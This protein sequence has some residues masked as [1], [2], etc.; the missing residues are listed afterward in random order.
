MLKSMLNI[1]A[2]SAVSA[3]TCQEA[4]AAD[5]SNVF[6]A[7]DLG[8]IG[9]GSPSTAEFLSRCYSHFNKSCAFYFY[10]Q[11]T[12]TWHI[13]DMPTGMMMDESIMRIILIPNNRSVI[14][15]Q[16]IS[17]RSGAGSGLSLYSYSS[18]TSTWYMS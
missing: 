4:S 7:S 10:Y 2:N 18:M 17:P 9:T 5:V 14:L 11:P 3:L 6:S 12:S 15:L 16:Q 1:Q 13:S 8:F